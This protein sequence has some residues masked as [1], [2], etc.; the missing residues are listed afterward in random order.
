MAMTTNAMP[1]RIANRRTWMRAD[2]RGIPG[3]TTRLTHVGGELC[4]FPPTM[5]ASLC[6]NA[7]HRLREPSL[8][9]SSEQRQDRQ[10]QDDQTNGDAEQLVRK[11]ACPLDV[12]FPALLQL[13]LEPRFPSRQ[14]RRRTA[15]APRSHRSLAFTWSRNLPGSPQITNRP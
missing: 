4:W 1:V 15:V 2:C 7:G 8:E 6:R 5:P 13:L 9:H 14:C 3:R 10:Q 12:L 11:R